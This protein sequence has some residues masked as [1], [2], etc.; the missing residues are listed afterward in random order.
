MS[1]LTPDGFAGFDQGVA[2]VNSL[3]ETYPRGTRFRLLTNTFASSSQITRSQGEVQEALTTA[4]VGSRIR[5]LPE[6]INRLQG[7]QT[8]PTL[9]PDVYLISDFQ[10][11]V[12]EVEE[13]LPLDSNW[14][15]YLAPIRYGQSENVWI[16]SAYLETPYLQRNEPNALNIALTNGGNRAQEDLLVKLY[17]NDIQVGN[18][19]VS[20]PAK[21]SGNLQ[22]PVNFPLKAHNRCRIAIEEFPVVFDNDFYF[23]LSLAGRIR[24]VEVKPDEKTTP[25]GRVYGNRNL[26]DFSAYPVSNVDYNALSEADLVVISGLNTWDQALQGALTRY[27][28]QGGTLAFFPGAEP[29]ANTF[30]QAVGLP[31]INAPTGP[32]VAINPP[33]EADPFFQN[34]F[35]ETTGAVDMPQVSPNLTWQP[36]RLPILKLRTG[37]PFLSAVYGKGTTYVFAS[38]Y[39]QDFGN[40][41]L[42]AVFVPIMYRMAVLS[43]QN[44]Q[45]LFYRLN[46]TTFSFPADSLNAESLYKLVRDGEEIIPAQR[47]VPGQL[48][49]EV[50]QQLLSPG[51]YTVMSPN[52]D[53]LSYLAFNLDTRES[54][55][56]NLDESQMQGLFTGTTVD[57]MEMDGRDG[58][59]AQMQSRQAGNSLWRLALWLTL[60]FLGV[61]IA[62][63]RLL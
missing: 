21:G 56:A 52:S 27:Q 15:L 50:P 63:V 47:V 22:F 61:E 17:V 54:Q 48:L 53:S 46:Q 49:M 2:A 42:H 23:T 4:T 51:Y 16:D 44:E 6:V 3:L 41:S 31:I 26:F 37:A 13:P 28:Q 55:L 29:N 18:A 38:P 36:Q 14:H 39:T 8:D 9:A 19:S 57:L 33:N 40:L 43:K 12:F 60:L 58:L 11:S 35:T 59:N 7:T 24:I 34:I 45:P 30:A 20:L 10:A 25:I 62:L 5:T 1:T 32:R